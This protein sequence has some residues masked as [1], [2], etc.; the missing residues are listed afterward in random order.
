MRFKVLRLSA[1]MGPDDGESAWYNG[2]GDGD[3]DGDDDM[4]LSLKLDVR[5]GRE[6]MTVSSPDSIPDCPRLTDCKNE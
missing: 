3:G 1:G 6:L 4:V 5:A 2:D